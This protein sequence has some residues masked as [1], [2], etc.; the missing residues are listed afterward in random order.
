MKN[1]NPEIDFYNPPLGPEEHEEEMQ[2][3]EK[4][5]NTGIRKVP[6][7]MVGNSTKHDLDFM[8]TVSQ[9][10][11][12]WDD[13]KDPFELGATSHAFNQ[14]LKEENNPSEDKL[15]AQGYKIQYIHDPESDMQCALI[16][17][18]NEVHIGFRGT[19][20]IKHMM[21]DLNSCLV[22]S[23]FMDEGRVHAGFYHGF[24]HLMP[25]LTA[26][27]D[28]H[29]KSEGKSLHDYD[30]KMTGH[31]MGGSLAKITALYMNKDWGISADRIRV[32]TF[33]DPRTFDVKGA[34]LYDEALGSNTVR[35][36]EHRQDIVPAMA[37]G[38][39]GFKHVGE[40]IRL[41]TPEGY[42][43]HSM[44][45]YQRAMRDIKDDEFVDAR[46]VSRLYRL[47]QAIRLIIDYIPE[48]IRHGIKK[49]KEKIGIKHWNEIV[50]KPESLESVELKSITPNT[51]PRIVSSS[52]K[53]P[54]RS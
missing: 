15:R 31:S 39:I 23:G 2:T 45:G 19:L 26:A 7:R 21:K 11:Y 28:A 50:K 4:L 34:A 51:T 10:A 13:P 9:F 22:T 18:G 29:A 48:K 41:K 17:R 5:N 44:N 49:V 30:Y 43:S 38:S 1:S 20:T 6:W 16:T 52:K 42:A 54:S 40:N 35:I 24:R 37:L 3:V 12:Q 14:Y 33:G 25:K 8:A 32:A 36:T 27:L 46:N 47:S 53:E